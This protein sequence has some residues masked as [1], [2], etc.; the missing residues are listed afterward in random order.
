M[1]DFLVLFAAKINAGDA[2]IP[3]NGANSVMLGVLN[4]IYIVAGIT[5]VIVII[6]GGIA[7]AISG[8]DVGKVKFARDTILYAL[9]GMVVVMLAFVLTNYVIGRF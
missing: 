4:T 8:G 1:K 2:G 6:F 3:T 5:A 9:I 7:F